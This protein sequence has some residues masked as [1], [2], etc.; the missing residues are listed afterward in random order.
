ML[1]VRRSGSRQQV[2][3][4]T[5]SDPLDSTLRAT[6][7]LLLA[8]SHLS[9]ATDRFQGFIHDTGSLGGITVPPCKYSGATHLAPL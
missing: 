8:R 2:V 6:A 1:L 3:E 4:R 5:F 9:P 7:K